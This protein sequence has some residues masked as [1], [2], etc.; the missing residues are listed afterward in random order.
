MAERQFKVKD[1][2][3]CPAQGVGEISDIVEKDIAGNRQTFYVVKLLDT[4]LRVMIPLTSARNI[5]MRELVNSSQIKVIMSIIAE[6]PPALDN[7]TWNR[8]YRGFMEKIK[9]GNLF[10]IAEVYRD[11][12]LLKMDKS[13][14]F[15]ERRMLDLARN[16]IV[17]EIS[18]SKK[19]DEKKVLKEVEKPIK[20]HQ[21]ARVA[22][23]HA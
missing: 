5:G 12:S 14:S 16:L 17:K 6:T 4:S 11:L 13:L 2:V 8:R 21:K 3:V 9:T 23:A 7:R 18:I 22:A 1:K 19:Q 10:D 20:K 15:G